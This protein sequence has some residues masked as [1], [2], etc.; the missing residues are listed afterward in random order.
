LW[1]FVVF[2]FKMF[3]PG[4]QGWTEWLQSLTQAARPAPPPPMSPPAA[5]SAAPSAGWHPLLAGSLQEQLQALLQ[6]QAQ[7]EARPAQPFPP[8][9]PA[10]PSAAPSAG[11]Q[12]PLLAGSPPAA[13]S[14]APSAGWQPPLL[15]GMMQEQLQA[16]VQQQI[17]IQQGQIEADAQQK[18]QIQINDVHAKNL[19]QIQIQQ[20]KA[21]ELA[22]QQAKGWQQQQPSRWQPQQQPSRRP[23]LSGHSHCDSCKFRTYIPRSSFLYTKGL[24]A[25]CQREAR[26]VTQQKH[27]NICVFKKQNASCRHKCWRSTRQL[28]LWQAC[29][30]TA[31]HNYVCH[32]AVVFVLTSD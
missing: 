29:H 32:V 11:W 16:L 22:R 26:F 24:M 7:A 15:A 1:S 19:Q 8:P 25:G 2:A 13:P 12:H 23:D 28:T 17:Q 20:A 3:S 5:P 10:A 27:A 21:D 9:P 31:L 18:I 30:L 6:Q 14:A 4:L